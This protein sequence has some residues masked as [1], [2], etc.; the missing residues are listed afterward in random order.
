MDTDK[1]IL[2][3]RVGFTSALIFSIILVLFDILYVVMARNPSLEYIQFFI[4]G[5][6][7]ILTPSFIILITTIYLL[8]AKS[9]RIWGL[10]GLC[11]GLSYS[12]IVSMVYFIQ[13]GVV[14]PNM[15]NDTMSEL[16]MINMSNPRSVVWAVNY[17]GWI[18]MGLATIFIGLSFGDNSSMRWVKRLFIIHGLFTIIA[19][20]GYL[21]DNFY[22]QMGVLFSWLLLLPVAT[23]ILA[24]KFRKRKFES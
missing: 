6:G 13:L 1:N 15:I 20:I 4:Y 7:L 16:E 10:I 23:F 24:I 5:L 9:L 3:L 19:M 12:I 11:F 2:L 22:L 18:F 21:L 17:L 8:S 14:L